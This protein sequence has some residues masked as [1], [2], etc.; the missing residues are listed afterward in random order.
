M[1]DLF[2]GQFAEK[3]PHRKTF[4]NPNTIFNTVIIVIANTPLVPGLTLSLY[5]VLY[6]ANGIT[7]V[8]KPLVARG[9]ERE[10]D[11]FEQYF[12][13][14]EKFL[15]AL[16]PAPFGAWATKKS[17]PVTKNGQR[18]S[19]TDWADSNQQAVIRYYHSLWKAYWLHLSH[20]NGFFKYTGSPAA[21]K[22][23]PDQLHQL[24]FCPSPLKVT[25]EVS[26]TP[27]GIVVTASATVK[28][29]W[30]DMTGGT[31]L[32]HFLYERDEIVYLPEAPLTLYRLG[33]LLQQGSRLIAPDWEKDFLE[34]DLPELQEEFSVTVA[35]DVLPQATVAATMS[36]VL[37]L[38]EMDPDLLVLKP[39]FRY[40]DTEVEFEPDADTINIYG[41]EMQVIRRDKAAELRFY[42]DLMTLHPLFAT[43]QNRHFFYLPIKEAVKDNWFFGLVKRLQEKGIATFGQTTLKKFRYNTH[44][45]ELSIGAGSN[46]DWFELKVLLQYGAQSV[47]LKQLRQAILNG[48]EY[49]Q[50]GDGTW[51]ILPEAWLKKLAT[52]FAIGQT[53]EQ[54]VKLSKQHF[55][56]MDEWPDHLDTTDVQ[57]ELTK[58][59][60]Q[61]QDLDTQAPFPLPQHLK[62]SL[63]PYQE[64]GYQWLRQLHQL[65]WGGCLAD[66]MGLGKT[67]Q[68][69]SFLLSVAEQN[70][71]VRMLIVCPTSLLFN[72]AAEIE[73]FT[74]ALRR[75]LY[76]GSDRQLPGDDIQVTLTSYGTL[77]NDLDQFTATV[78]D[79]IV[80]DESQSIKNPASQ[81]AKAIQGLRAN[82][83]FVLSGT[84]IQNNTLDLYPQLHF[85]NPGLLGSL[86]AFK[87]RFAT[88]IDKFGDSEATAQLKK[89]VNPFLLR[90]TKAQVAQDLPDKTET[91]VYCEMG[92]YQREVYD[93][94]KDDYRSR[95]LEE[96][97][98]KGMA[99]SLF[100]LLEGLNKLR[101]IC[102]CPSLVK[103]ED[104]KRFKKASVKVEE[105]LRELEDNGGDHKTLVFSQ[106]TGMLHLVEEALI[107]KGIPFLYLDGKTSGKERGRL[108]Q[109]FQQ[110]AHI[111]VFLISLKAGGVGLNLTAADYVYLLDPWWNPAAEDQAI[112][113][114]HR[115]GQQQKVF[116]YKMICKD[117]VEEKIIRLQQKKKQLVSA[118]VTEDTGFVKKL[119]LE[120]V[121]FLLG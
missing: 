68:T 82:S 52:L 89:I 117:T 65:G 101:L 98:E 57:E 111:R 66:D 108:V 121:A 87:T 97:A 29:Q 94:V 40:E 92:A 51:G 37:V 45:P 43:Q 50:L 38:S 104:G 47:S 80:L 20:H 23:E 91:I 84:P 109:E 18:L 114:A 75:H 67:L 25:V 119:S 5:P 88:P 16:Q 44:L 73:K 55:T 10:K 33:D 69:L 58:R 21:P 2:S 53:D 48:Q 78:Y 70:E 116:A 85:T 32:Q 83:R 96:A 105:L 86:S 1:S 39:V 36:A 31:V 63:R 27:A 3:T 35:D 41:T 54:L 93:A 118:L 107:E 110:Q 61:L 19:F 120:D 76:H 71:Q 95:I 102:D 30:L 103:P 14:L 49:V 11:L 4:A 100:L 42:E 81:I 64:A 74:P 8:G 9:S 62:A 90:R 106:F 15:T 60:Q 17:I 115:I 28:G 77:R 7:R 13:A 112:D 34:K 6:T 99:G 79:V 22:P 56:L 72:W 113:R 26:R 24:R 59:K 46:M 12:G